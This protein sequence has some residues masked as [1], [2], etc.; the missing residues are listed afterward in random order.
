LFGDAPGAVAE[1]EV[2]VSGVPDRSDIEKSPNLRVLVIPWAGLPRKTRE[3]LLDHREIETHNIHHN[4][5]P[6][7]ELAVALFLAAAKRLLV[8]DRALRAA[9]WRPRYG[10]DP[11]PTLEGRRAL[12]L[13]Y[14]AIGR[15]VA[16]ACR[17][18][19][20]QVTGLRRSVRPDDARAE[21]D[22]RTVSSLDELLPG[23][24]ALFVCVPLT[25]ETKGMVD[26]RRLSLLPEQAV[27]VN[28]ARGRV[29]D[30]RALYDALLSGRLAGAGVDVWYQYPK[31]E[32]ERADTRPSE[33]PFHELDNVVMS[34]HRGGAFMADDTERRRVEAL[35]RVLNALARGVP[36]PNRVDVER[37]Y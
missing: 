10:S 11:S 7:A 26:A 4:A 24:S 17:G 1:R 8:M 12:V 13:G 16:A 14:G 35:A 23:C 22:V 5:A 30:E 37:G 9:D 19:G 34:P 2:L 29:V 33:F 21:D 36:A 18:L 28:I 3:I 6:V 20:M 27:L 25:D 32:E 31:D 15:R